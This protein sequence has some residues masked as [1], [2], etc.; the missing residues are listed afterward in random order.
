MK[1]KKIAVTG[2]N[3]QLGKNLK[4][5]Q[6]T[7]KISGDWT[8]FSS[9]ELD[10]T[11]KDHLKKC[12]LNKTFDYIINCAAYTKVDQAE[13][14][15]QE[16]ENVNSVA[17]KNL[18]EICEKSNITLIHISTDFVFGGKSNKPIQENQLPDPI[19][20]YRKTKFAG[21][22]HLQQI[23]SQYFIL[24]TGWLYSSIGHNFFST[25]K[26]LGK[27]KEELNVIYDQIG[28][29]THTSVLIQAIYEILK[30]NSEA[31]GIYHAANEGI[32]SWYDFAY[33]ILKR[34]KS[35]CKV[36]PILSEEYPTP[37]KRPT[38]S[39]LDKSKF[40]QTFEVDFPHWRESLAECF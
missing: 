40:K 28:T 3:G 12:F 24:R 35:P 25:M 18:A 23:L 11:K 14:E 38:F 37:A 5:R 9:A 30:S 10:I 26:R 15:K 29:P 17:V 39:V 7:E 8:Y 19:N 27:E 34:S 22:Q 1:H 21:E 32:A 13:T 20:F 36:N 16:A 6:Q 4:H 33:E 31:Y 2:A